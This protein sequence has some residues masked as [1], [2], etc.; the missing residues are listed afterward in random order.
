MHQNK[1][2]YV[3]VRQVDGSYGNV[4]IK[5]F[6]HIHQDVNDIN[7]DVTLLGSTIYI[8]IAIGPLGNS[9]VLFHD[10]ASRSV[11]VAPNVGA[12]SMQAK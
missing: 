9:V 7:D 6:H 5:Q 8:I 3:I 11:I 10:K 12:T 4:W 1:S 2:K